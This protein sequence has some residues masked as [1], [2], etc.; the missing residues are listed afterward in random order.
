MLYKIV[1]FEEAK[2]F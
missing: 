1:V 2:I